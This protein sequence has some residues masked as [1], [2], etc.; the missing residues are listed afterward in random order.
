MC[1]ECLQ[2]KKVWKCENEF[3]R[4]T[5]ANSS[6]ASIL[7]WFILVP[8]ASEPLSEFKFSN[9]AYCS[10]KCSVMTDCF[11]S[12]VV[13]CISV[14]NGLFFDLVWKTIKL[15]ENIHRL[16]IWRTTRSELGRAAWKSGWLGL[17]VL[18]CF[19]NTSQ[20]KSCFVDDQSVLF[21]MPSSF[22]VP[23]CSQKGWNLSNVR[24]QGKIVDP[25]NSLRRRKCVHDRRGNWS[26]FA[27]F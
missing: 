12:Y 7:K 26:L 3:G 9:L 21:A 19:D 13:C 27:I 14:Q 15:R 2:R 8:Y 16:Q 4:V 11:H 18:F 10:Y 24:F 5:T 25:C 1:A 17:G 23:E 6:C 20:E 22:C